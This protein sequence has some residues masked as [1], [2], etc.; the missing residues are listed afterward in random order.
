MY[1][2]KFIMKN[3]IL[4]LIE[5]VY[6][7]SLFLLF[8]L[9]LFPGSLIGFLLHGDMSRELNLVDNPIGTSINHFFYFVYLTILAS[10]C[11]SR[12]KIF[13]NNFYFIFLL[14]IILE[15]SHLVIP[16]RAFELNDLFA[17]IA[18]VVTIIMIKKILK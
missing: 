18:G 9:Y 6:Y 4:K 12:K 15:S 7:L 2:I 5:Y 16:N 17:N 11:S 10:V 1:Y 14:S 3:N 8:A 13:F